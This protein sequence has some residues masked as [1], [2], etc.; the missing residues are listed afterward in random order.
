M[1]STDVLLC[2]VLPCK[3]CCRRV[4]FWCWTR[5]ALLSLTHR[6][7][8]SPTRT[9][10]STDSPKSTV[11]SSDNDVHLIR[12]VALQYVCR[13]HWL[14]T[15]THIFGTWQRVVLHLSLYIHRVSKNCAK[16]FLP[17]LR[18]ISTNFDNFW[19]TD[20]TKDRFMWGALI[21]HLT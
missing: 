21:F 7:N 9:E 1:L 19:H 5:G 6:S 13:V 3:W 16:L 4:E 17:V 15:V 11:S 20:S 8:Y 10:Y 18:Q 12:S 14:A 2:Y